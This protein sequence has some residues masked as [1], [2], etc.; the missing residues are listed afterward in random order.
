MCAFGR[1]K[2]LKAS[3]IADGVSVEDLVL[4][5]T[6]EIREELVT[7]DPLHLTDGVDVEILLPVPFC[8]PA[9]EAD[10]PRR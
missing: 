8:V 7:G 1:K 10:A 9:D 2:R 6:A 4:D 5:G 3:P